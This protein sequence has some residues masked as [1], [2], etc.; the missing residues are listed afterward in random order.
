MLRRKEDLKEWQKE[1]LKDKVEKVLHKPVK[2]EAPK[3]E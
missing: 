2:K 3:V 1:S